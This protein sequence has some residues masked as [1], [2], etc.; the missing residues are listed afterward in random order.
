M[1]NLRKSWS[2]IYLF[3][4]GAILNLGNEHSARAF[5]LIETSL[6]PAVQLIAGQSANIKVTNVSANTIIVVLTTYRDNG[7]I[8]TQE[9]KSIA[10]G[11]TLTF[12]VK[13]PANDPLSF[14]ATLGSDTAQAALA[15]VMTFDIDNG[16]AIA[17]LPFIKLDTQ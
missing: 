11:T 7:A 4:A 12:A 3:A 9:T 14:H 10:T 15:D 17:I 5:T 6:L 1:R 13:A 8:I 16:E 2:P